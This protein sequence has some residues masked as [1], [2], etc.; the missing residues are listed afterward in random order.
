MEDYLRLVSPKTF[1]FAA[2]PRVNAPSLAFL[3]RAVLRPRA[4]LSHPPGA[5]EI[6]SRVPLQDT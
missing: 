4:H 6:E 1:H 3:R 5:E 2:W